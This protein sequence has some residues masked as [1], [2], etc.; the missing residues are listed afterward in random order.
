MELVR[1]PA[2]KSIC[3][4][5][6]GVCRAA[7]VKL[8]AA[9]TA[10]FNTLRLCTYQQCVS[11]CVVWFPHWRIFP[12]IPLTEPLRI[13]H[14][15]VLNMLKTSPTLFLLCSAS[16]YCIVKYQH[17]RLL[18]WWRFQIFVSWVVIVRF[19]RWY[20]RYRWRTMP[21][22]TPKDEKVCISETSVST[23]Q[24]KWCHNPETVA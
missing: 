15:Y 5:T 24:T 3:R 20:R 19:G 21:S 10:C 11:R 14:S 22:S 2:V 6:Y 4:K 12:K 23:Y 18:Q 16:R 1:R 13:T 17:S 7:V 9:L 8:I